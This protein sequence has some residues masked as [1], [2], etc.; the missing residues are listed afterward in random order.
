MPDGLPG[1]DDWLTHDP[2]DVPVPWASCT[3]TLSV[4]V[5]LDCP[6]DDET[7]R[8]ILPDDPWITSIVQNSWETD[9][10]VVKA[11]VTGDTWYE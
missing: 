1:Y 11:E 9:V 2:N 6:L 8:P 3:V 10:K 5:T 7:R 4:Q